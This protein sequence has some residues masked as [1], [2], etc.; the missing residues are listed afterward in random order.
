MYRHIACIDV[1]GH[2]VNF[3]LTQ[4]HAMMLQTQAEMYVSIYLEKDNSPIPSGTVP[5]RLGD[6]TEP[7]RNLVKN[8]K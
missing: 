6:I 4:G 3:P 8:E 5:F 7:E 2:W 1:D